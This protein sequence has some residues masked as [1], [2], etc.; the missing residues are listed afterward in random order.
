M[1][2]SSLNY[3]NYVWDL[4]DYKIWLAHYTKNTPYENYQIWQNSCTGTISGIN[5]AV[6][7]DIIKR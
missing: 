7:F 4:K 3:L 5:G 1:L 2:Y 6:D